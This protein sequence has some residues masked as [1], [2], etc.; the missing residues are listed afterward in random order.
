MTTKTILL[1]S[2]LC[3]FD[4][5]TKKCETKNFLSGRY[6]RFESAKNDEIIFILFVFYLG[7]YAIKFILIIYLRNN[8]LNI[9]QPS[10]KRCKIKNTT[11]ILPISISN[12][13]ISITV[14]IVAWVNDNLAAIAGNLISSCILWFT[15]EMKKLI[16]AQYG[17]TITI[18]IYC[19]GEDTFF[20]ISQELVWFYC[21]VQSILSDPEN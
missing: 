13:I 15:A 5:F 18:I 4:R 17:R 16:Q 20:W 14:T 19:R 12:C 11:N 7:M 6:D 21:C 1:F 8:I 9:P 3:N 2:W 10:P